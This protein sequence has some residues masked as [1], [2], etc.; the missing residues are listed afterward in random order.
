MLPGLRVGLCALNA[1][2]LVRIQGKH[3]SVSS[4]VVERSVEAREA[5]G[6]S[7]V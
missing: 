4:S 7:P 1:S 5:T 2:V 3:P 6:S